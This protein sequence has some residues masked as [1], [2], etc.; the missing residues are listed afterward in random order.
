MVIVAPGTSEMQRTGNGKRR[1][2]P[3]MR[4]E[5]RMDQCFMRV[6]T[7]VILWLGGLHPE[8]KRQGCGVGLA[9]G[10]VFVA[11]A[12]KLT[13]SIRNTVVFVRLIA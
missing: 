11:D 9:S 7:K 5:A 1:S 6:E 10:L 4:E 13:L 2:P 3:V 12:R 8:R